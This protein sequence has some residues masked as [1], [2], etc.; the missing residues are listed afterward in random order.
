MMLHVP[1][2][3]VAI[4]CMCVLGSY[5][6]KPLVGSVFEGGMA[7]CFAYGQTGSGK[8][9]VSHKSNTQEERLTHILLFPRSTDYGRSIRWEGA[10]CGQRGLCSGW[11]VIDLAGSC[12]ILELL[13]NAVC[14]W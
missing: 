2:V 9:H 8:T 12:C 14:S 10:R 13:L 5:T 7:T 3:L 4:T 11:Y 6:A 1:P